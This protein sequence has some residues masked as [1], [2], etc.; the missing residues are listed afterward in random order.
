[1]FEDIWMKITFFYAMFRS[2]GISYL[3]AVLKKSGFDVDL[4][5]SDQIF[6]ANTYVAEALFKSEDIYADEILATSPALIAFS[7]GTE[8]YARDL[9]LARIIKRKNPHKIIVF[10]GM[11]PSAAPKAVIAESAVDYVCVGEGEEAMVDLAVAIRDGG[12]TTIIPNIWSKQDSQI[13]QNDV[14]ELISDLDSL[15]FPDTDLFMEKSGTFF[16]K[17][18]YELLAGRG[19]YNKC[20]FCYNSSWRTLY[21][22]VSPKYLR[23]RSVDNVIEELRQAKEKY[24]INHVRI[25]DDIFFYGFQWMYDFLEK[26]EKYINLPFECNLHSDFVTE[27]LIGKMK[28]AGGGYVSVTLAAE[29]IDPSTRQGVFERKETNESFINAIDVLRRNNIYVYSHII[30]YLP[31]AQEVKQLIDTAVFFNK[32]KVDVLGLPPLRYYPGLK[33]TELGFYKQVLSVDDLEQIDKGE[34][35]RV[36]TTP[37]GRKNKNVITLAIASS[38]L[39]EKVLNFLLCKTAEKKDNRLL[40]AFLGFCF[41]SKEFIKQLFRPKELSAFYLLMLFFRYEIFCVLRKS[42]AN[43]IAYIKSKKLKTV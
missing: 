5:F 12:D 36:N 6:A 41:W 10:G 22:E 38:F 28:K 31:I 39:P 23:F 37:D 21:K 17:N 27:E 42:P 43:M 3:S 1:M 11:H 29:S 24:K 35:F 4:V 25:W 19:C 20:T 2:L 9:N 7:S 30:V 32:H 13:Y 18:C 34:N 15:P 40:I 8:N 14:R 26:Y 16:S 33:I